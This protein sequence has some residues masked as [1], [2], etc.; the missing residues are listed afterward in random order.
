MSDIIETI[1]QGAGQVL[2]EIDQKGQLKSALQGIRAQWNELERR[3]KKGTLESEIKAK[4]SEMKQLV[5]ALGLQTLS[6][7]DAGTITHPELARLCERLNELRSEIDQRKD[8]LAALLKQTQGQTAKCPLCSASVPAG[9]EF[10]PKCGAQM[11][12]KPAGPAVGPAAKPQTVVRMRCPKCKTTLPPNSGFCPTCGVKFKRPQAQPAGS[13]FCPA[14][15]AETSAKARFCP[16][17]GQ[18]VS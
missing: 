2:S 7:F 3:R 17:C 15:G 14:C 12:S 13:Q 8:E 16:I 18:A 6:L 5:E 4:Q 1:K 9:S 10:C 11:G